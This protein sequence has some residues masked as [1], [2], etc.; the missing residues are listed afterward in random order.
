MVN[1]ISPKS[2][3]VDNDNPDTYTLIWEGSLSGGQTSYEVL[4]REKGAEEWL[5]TGRVNSS[6]TSYDL[7]S[8]YDLVG[9]DFVEIEYKVTL[10]FD[11][12]DGDV[13]TVGTESSNVFSLI[14]NEGISG[15]LNVWVGFE[16]HSYPMFDTIKNTNL[17]TMSINTDDGEKKIPLVEA[18]N[19]LAKDMKIQVASDKARCLAGYSP[20]FAYYTPKD[21]DVFGE[22]DV[23]ATGTYKYTDS[24]SYISQYGYKYSYLNYTERKTYNAFGGSYSY[25]KITVTYFRE[26]VGAVYGYYYYYNHTLALRRAYRMF[27]SYYYYAS[28][29]SISTA[30]AY[31][32][33]RSYGSFDN[34]SYKYTND[35]YSDGYYDATGNYSYN[36]NYTT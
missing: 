32:Y 33:Y 31:Y 2:S 5:T 10:T 1:I 22:F 18:D 17:D 3:Y 13:S 14:F 16:K 34:Y 20:N 12:T 36:Y 8:I 9:I 4:Y 29:S 23:S 7:R 19:V 28:A 25:D 6:E 24:Y 26:Y 35:T 21:T 15:N 27:D 11:Y 30:Y